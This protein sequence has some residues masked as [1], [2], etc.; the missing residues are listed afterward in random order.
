MHKK[1][2]M[3]GL[4]RALRKQFWELFLAK[5]QSSYS[6]ETRGSVKTNRG[7]MFGLDARIALAIF[8]ALSVISGAALYSAIKQAQVTSAAQRIIEFAKATEAYLIDVKKDMPESVSTPGGIAR[9]VQDLL[10]STARG[11]GGPY[12]D[13]EITGHDSLVKD[14]GDVTFQWYLYWSA[15]EDWGDIAGWKGNDCSAGKVCYYFMKSHISNIPGTQKEEFALSLD[16]YLDGGDGADKGNLRI[17]WYLGD[18]NE[19]ILFYRVA[20]TFKKF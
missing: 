20:P 13:V 19:P 7:A 11:W 17:L 8:G 1:G 16:E 5:R 4:F 10:D 9:R 14:E 12:L 2:A 15:N 3:F 18:R 6:P